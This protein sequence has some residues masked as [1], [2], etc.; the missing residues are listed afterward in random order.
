MTQHSRRQTAT[1]A[2]RH[3][4]KCFRRPPSSSW[5]TKSTWSALESFLRKVLEHIR[6]VYT[7]KRIDYRRNFTPKK[8][9]RIV[10]SIK[11]LLLFY[12]SPYKLPTYCK[13][14]PPIRIH[15]DRTEKGENIS[16]ATNI[17]QTSLVNSF[18]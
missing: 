8:E 18:V 5:P 4:S 6:S 14:P 3:R 11:K 13:D 15:I 2:G 1:T 16:K 17:F 9:I 7:L 12:T 10:T